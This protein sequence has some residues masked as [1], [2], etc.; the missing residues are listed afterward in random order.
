M[1]LS[2]T[3][4]D[5][6][7]SNSGTITCGDANLTVNAVSIGQGAFTAPSASGSFII[8]GEKSG[9]AFDYDGNQFIHNS[10]T[11]DIRTQDTTLVDFT[12]NDAAHIDI[13]NVIINHASCIATLPS[14]GGIGGALT[15]TAGKFDCAGY[16][17]SVGSVTIADGAEFRA[18]SG[19]TTITSHASNWTLKN[20]E[21]DG[22]GYVHNN[23]TLAIETNA[24]GLRIDQGGSKLNNLKIGKA[25]GADDCWVQYQTGLVIL[26]NL[27]LLY[28]ANFS[29][30]SN[31]NT[32]TVHGITNIGASAIL[33]NTST[34]GAFTYYGLITNNGT[35]RTGSGTN[36]LNGGG[37]NLG[38]FT[39]DDTLTI[40]GTGG[41]LE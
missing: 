21:T 32:L 20:E 10:G 14:A 37:R 2:D 12:P 13:N 27:D 39:S 17:L 4:S 1:L 23:G 22:T 18:S 16:D 24:S 31:G 35:F 15:I 30:Y 3:G 29:S 36:N 38:S 8:T 26:G 41:I 34:S 7:C 5:L 9:L 6:Y 40:G 33:G 11:I 19:T 28:H 25:S